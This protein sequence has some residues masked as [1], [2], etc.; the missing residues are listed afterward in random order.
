MWRPPQHQID[1]LYSEDV[2]TGYKGKV[3]KGDGYK[4]G[5]A[6]LAAATAAVTLLPGCCSSYKPLDKNDLRPAYLQ[7]GPFNYA[8]ELDCKCKELGEKGDILGDILTRAGWAFAVVNDAGEVVSAGALKTLLGEDGENFAKYVFDGTYGGRTFDEVVY[9]ELLSL[10][11]KGALD[12][13]YDGEE[14]ELGGHGKLIIIGGSIAAPI[15]LPLTL[16]KHGR[17]GAAATTVVGPGQTPI[18]PF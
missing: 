4:T 7:E 13:I 12:R 3:G 18:D 2:G 5:R 15:V 11:L 16:I 14:N 6:L 17:D 9:G 1:A 10:D 8:A